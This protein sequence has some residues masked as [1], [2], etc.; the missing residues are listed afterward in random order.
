[1]HHL[2]PQL[3]LSLDGK[4]K[5]P[6]NK[7]NMINFNGKT[8]EKAPNFCGPAFHSGTHFTNVSEVSEETSHFQL[9]EKEYVHTKTALYLHFIFQQS[10]SNA[11]FMHEFPRN[12]KNAIT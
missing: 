9:V 10:L 4:V 7:I 11:S 2:F 6:I 8:F 12:A 5:G 1:M 3:F